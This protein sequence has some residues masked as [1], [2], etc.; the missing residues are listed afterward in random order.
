MSNHDT[1][2]DTRPEGAEAVEP[3]GPEDAASPEGPQGPDSAG[4]A[5]AGD[6]RIAGLRSHLIIGV[7]LAMLGF[8]VVAQVRLTQGENLSALRQD[9]LV[10]LL[11]EVTRRNEQLES[12]RAELLAARAELLSGEDSRRIAE[13][14]AA[15]RAEV[16]GVLAGT[17]PVEGP[18][19]TLEVSDPQARVGA[20]TQFNVLQEM[21]NAGAEAVEVS[22]VR[23]VGSSWFA[24]ADGGVIVDGQLLQPP[25]TWTAIGDPQTMAV[26]LDIPG[27]ALASIRN[28][29]GSATLE[30]SELLRITSVLQV[31]GTDRATPV[32]V[33]SPAP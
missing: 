5:P 6:R 23:L 33:P 11:D 27:G 2:A 8:A 10:R 22:G 21:R 17:L 30:Q 26:A 14:A 12:E 13:E 32:P 31:G 25:Y 29:G 19:I 24:D 15:E 9:D 4:E 16:L 28:A 7:L 3:G 1:P 18:G 20:L